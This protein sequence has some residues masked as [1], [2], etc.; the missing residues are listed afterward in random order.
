M[1]QKW[2]DEMPVL[3]LD[4]G[5]LILVIM[6]RGY[7]MVGH[8]SGHIGTHA[9]NLSYVLTF[10]EEVDALLESIAPVNNM[11]PQ[12]AYQALITVIMPLLRNLLQMYKA[13]KLGWI[14]AYM[15][16]RDI[17][18]R[19]VE[20]Q[21]SIVSRLCSSFGNSPIGIPTPVELQEIE[22]HVKIALDALMNAA[23]DHP[24]NMSIAWSSADMIMDEYR[25]IEMVLQQ[26]S[27]RKIALKREEKRL[28][29]KR[30]L[31]GN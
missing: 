20:I 7:T 15:H 12:Q 5:G 3:W 22:D 26:V 19:S 24:D 23:N 18:N 11:D 28:S 9:P 30:P 31:I 10:P 8:S 25:N 29:L 21:R 13:L 27:D 4:D 14:F 6:C 1:Q 16:P 2:C 17:V